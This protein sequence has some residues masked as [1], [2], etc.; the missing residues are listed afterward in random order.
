MSI[1]EILN[2]LAADNSRLAKEAILKRE[3]KNQTLKA[4][5]KAAYDPFINYWQIKIP[6]YKTESKPWHTLET[7]LPKL[8]KLIRREVTGNEAIQY[9]SL[10]LSEFSPDDAVVVERIIQH[11]L[12]CGVAT[13]TINKIWDG[14]IPT[15]D[16]CL[17]H[18]DISA[19]KYPAYA[20]VKMDGGRCHINFD[21]VEATAWSRNGKKIEFHGAFNEIA[22]QVMKPGETWDGEI[23]FFENGKAMD[24]KTSNG[25][26][27]KGVKGTISKEEAAKA[28]FTCWDIVDFS[29][30]HPYWYRYDEM[31]DR[32]GNGVQGNIRIV[33]TIIVNNEEEAYE[34][35]GEC[36]KNGEEG[37]ILKNKDFKWEPKRVKGVGKMKAEEEAD[38]RVMSYVSGTG[39]YT[40]MLGALI[41]RTEDNIIEVNVGSGFSDDERKLPPEYWLDKVITV[42]YNQRIK[43]QGN[44][45]ESLFLPRFVCLR[46]PADKNVA[47]TSDELK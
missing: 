36:L 5:F 43:A 32:F 2:E 31:V 37:A 21:G 44:K 28:V 14:L 33:G 11:D 15:F 47:N 25:L 40:G 20:Q 1:L 45:K 4:V 22:K 29:G 16:V 17:A 38:L 42:R 24:R 39:K 9:L 34:F 26:F 3:E 10:L 6:E 18:K 46:D 41:C 35:Y 30:K 23:V 19:I 8:D 13:P 27:N 7:G 12:R